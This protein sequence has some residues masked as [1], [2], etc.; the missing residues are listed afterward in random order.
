MQYANL[1]AL[2]YGSSSARRFFLALPVEIQIA[3]QA[4][5]S[6]IHTAADL[7]RRVEFVVEAQRMDA[8]GGWRTPRPGE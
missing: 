4:H 5:G 7:H 3:M 8:L 1:H 2:V 6:N